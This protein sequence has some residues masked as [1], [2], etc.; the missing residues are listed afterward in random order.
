MVA[1]ILPWLVGTLCSVI[2]IILGPVVTA[3]VA[4]E[5]MPLFDIPLIFFAGLPLVLF[6]MGFKFVARRRS[7]WPERR[8]LIGSAATL[9]VACGIGSYL[10]FV[11]FSHAWHSKFS[12]ERHSVAYLFF[13]P[14]E[15]R[16]VTVR[17]TDISKPGEKAQVQER[18]WYIITFVALLGCGPLG[19]MFIERPSHVGVNPGLAQWPRSGPCSYCGGSGDCYCKRKGQDPG[20]CK[21]CGRT[22]KCHVCQGAGL[23]GGRAA[24]ILPKR[25]WQ[26]DADRFCNRCGP[27][28]LFQ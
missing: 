20:Q 26:A 27:N 7:Q 3:Y 1:R 8:T 13:H 15:I 18:S 11:G 24:S 25:T 2:G 10:A 17:T 22:G 14:G 19:Y 16:P 23:V 21:R 9:A 6:A 28:K 12:Q 5:Q 4:R